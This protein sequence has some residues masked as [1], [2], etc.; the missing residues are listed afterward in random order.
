MDSVS[1]NDEISTELTGLAYRLYEVE[2]VAKQIRER[3]ELLK[4]QLNVL[5]KVEKTEPVESEDLEGE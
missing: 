5:G 4:G 2:N 3:M 1:I